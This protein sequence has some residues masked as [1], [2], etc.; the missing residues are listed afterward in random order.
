MM[1]DAKIIYEGKEYH[2][3][4]GLPGYYGSRDGMVLS[5]KGRSPR[6][7]YRAR[8]GNSEAFYITLPSRQDVAISRSRVAYMVQNEVEYSALKGK[9]Y[10]LQP[11]GIA[12]CTS[13]AELCRINVR[14]RDEARKRE[15]RK[16]IAEG[17]RMI[18]LMERYLDTGD[19]TEIAKEAEECKRMVAASITTAFHLSMRM[20]DEI[21][22]EAVS[23]TMWNIGRGLVV[24]NMVDYIMAVAKRMVKISQK[25]RR[26]I[27]SINRDLE[28]RGYYDF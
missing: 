28:D 23:E 12:V 15:P 17:K 20:A 2:R 8:Y 6:L 26:R 14:K 9:T 10:T 19:L 24:F 22:N 18:G 27:Y 11:D 25:E 21:A 5:Q 13:Q 4:K 16:W 7:L 3:L 1:E